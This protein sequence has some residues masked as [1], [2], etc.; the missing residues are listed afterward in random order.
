[1][2]TALPPFE[3]TVNLNGS[4]TLAW[5]PLPGA[6]FYVGDAAGQV[7]TVPTPIQVS[8]SNTYTFYNLSPASYYT[9]EVGATGNWPGELLASTQTELTYPV[10]PT[11][12]ETSDSTTAVGLGLSWT[13]VTGANVS[14][15]LNVQAGSESNNISL[16]AGTTSVPVT[17]LNP[18]V[19]YTFTV[20]AT[21]ATGTNWSNP[22]SVLTYP[23]APTFTLAGT[24]PY[25]VQVSWSP[26]GSATGY[27]VD[28]LIDLNGT[29][30]YWET[31]Q[32]TTYT[33]LSYTDYNLSS[34]TPYTFRVDAINGS[35][36]TPA[37]GQSITTPDTNSNW[38]GY[39][40]VPGAVT[41]PN[42]VTE[43]G[44][45]W[46]Q[47]A[48]SSPYANAA[49]S[50]WVGTSTAK[51]GTALPA[52]PSNKSARPGTP[53]R[54]PILPGSNSLGMACGTP[55]PSSGRPKGRT[56]TSSPSTSCPARNS[57]SSPGTRLPRVWNTL[58]TSSRQLPYNRRVPSCS[59]SRISRCGAGKRLVGVPLCPPPTSSPSER[60]RN[61]LSKR[62]P[63]VLPRRPRCTP[64]RT[65]AR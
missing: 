30:M 18:G 35:G 1:M 58:A 44:G 26:V 8:N 55:R 14:Y 46:V 41:P 52:I 6:T 37:V 23:A 61:G 50:I 20:G 65:L 39:V 2:P 29:L 4:V 13:N 16:T 15:F 60:P 19:N 5:N 34:Y 11:L 32:N 48:I 59:G 56:S 27:E 57:I 33:T 3:A 47:P 36:T 63:Q 12:T 45:S 21:N 22:L 9:F 53:P 28:M 49:A 31:L 51:L 25:S 43:V 10:A 54:N 62:P 40:I 42:Q 7:S 38:S 64:Y 17:G 24:S